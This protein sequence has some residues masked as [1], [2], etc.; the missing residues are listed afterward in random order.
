MGE[1]LVARINAPA[2]DGRYPDTTVYLDLDQSVALKRRIQATEAD[3]IELNADDFHRRVQ[4]AFRRLHAKNPERYLRVDAAGAAEEIAQ[5]VYR[6]VV[7]RMMRDG[8][9]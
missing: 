6:E 3:R 4:D 5:V 9:A 8:V 1:E 2:V 7:L